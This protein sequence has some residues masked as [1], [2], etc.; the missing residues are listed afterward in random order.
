MLLFIV[1][2]ALM[3]EVF[4]VS[5]LQSGLFSDV[6]GSHDKLFSHLVDGG[7]SKS[8]VHYSLQQSRAGI[9]IETSQITFETVR[10]KSE[11]ITISCLV[12]FGHH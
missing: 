7:S 3:D 5:F 6:H 9:S 11:M 1:V 4:S 8:T 2:D 10:I 12:E